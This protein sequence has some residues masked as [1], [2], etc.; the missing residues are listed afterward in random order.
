MRSYASSAVVLSNAHFYCR[1]AKGAHIP[2]FM[3]VDSWRVDKLSIPRPPGGAPPPQQ[4]LRS[5]AAAARLVGSNALAVAWRPDLCL[6]PTLSA[7]ATA[8]SLLPC[9][10]TPLPLS[11][12]TPPP[13]RAILQGIDSNTLAC[14]VMSADRCEISMRGVQL[15]SAAMFECS[16]M[17]GLV[18]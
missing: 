6:S 13:V 2:P 4:K 8:A 14:R 17:V 5:Q 15:D 9:R 10:R 16:S 3:Q 1:H 11:S 12:P 18:M 7:I